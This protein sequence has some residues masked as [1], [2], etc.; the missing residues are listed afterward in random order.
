[1]K[2][3]IAGFTMIELIVVIAILGLLSTIGL[4][5]F[6]TAQIKGRDA[7]RKSDLTQIQK[8]LEIYY[9]DYGYYPT[10]DYPGSGSFTDTKGTLYIKEIPEDPRFGTYPYSS[11]GTFYILYARLENNQDP[12]FESGLCKDYGLTCGDENCNYAVASPNQIL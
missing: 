9:N 1:M 8:A 12:C 7:Q 6:R 2:K 3:K 10:D 4:V 5:S 11:D